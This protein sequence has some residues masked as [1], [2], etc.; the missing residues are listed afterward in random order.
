MKFSSKQLKSIKKS[1]ARINIW[2]GAVRSGK[3]HA[4]YYRW[5]QYAY[6]GPPGRLYMV[7]KTLET[8][9]ENLLDP[10]KELFNGELQYSDSG[11][12]IKFAGRDI[13]GIGANDEKSKGKI[14]GGTCAGVLADEITLY[15][16]TFFKM[17][18][19]RLS[20]EGAK[21]FGTCNPDSPY[22][23]LKTDFIDNNDLDLKTFHF[24]ID[25][26]PFL[27]S[28]YV[29]NLKLEYSGV[30]YKRYID[31]LWALADG[32]IYDMFDHDV[33]VVDCK[34]KR[35]QHY[36]AGC[37]YGTSNP[38]AF[39]LFGYNTPDKVCLIKEFYYDSK[40]KNDNKERKTKT[41]SEYA[42]DVEAFL[43]GYSV[44]TIWID[45]SA[46]SFQTELTRRG[47]PVSSA[48]NS[49]LEG[50]KFVA[51]MLKK[52]KFV[53][54]ESCRMTLKEFETY[55]WDE[56]AQLRGEDKPLKSND[57]A[58]D[59]IRYVLYSQFGKGAGV[60]ILTG[61][62]NRQAYQGSINMRGF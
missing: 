44:R 7:G 54:D 25:E 12:R 2:Q 51:G 15:P 40:S 3:T 43:S 9:R 18:L 41:D 58:M 23:W 34:G 53:I 52:D 47:L 13:R 14:Q 29:K 16:E 56:K 62:P 26:N 37:D 20:V 35:F 24:T 8:L 21:F 31:G 17:L 50:I 45:P 30:W 11:R 49:V 10:M 1:D 48:D 4:S 59:M 6:M 22:H 5:A 60:E 38:F 61:T 19:S 55:S 27:P 42:D 28:N 33:H 46:L 32:L 36:I 57:H 39:G